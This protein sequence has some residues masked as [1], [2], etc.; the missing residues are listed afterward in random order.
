MYTLRPSLSSSLSPAS[1]SSSL[2]YAPIF[3]HVK[4]HHLDGAALLKGAR[5]DESFRRI[6]VVVVGAE[7]SKYLNVKRVERDKALLGLFFG[8]D[9]LLILTNSKRRFDNDNSPIL[10][11][12]PPPNRRLSPT[13]R[14]PRPPRNSLDAR[15]PRRK[16]PLMSRFENWER[17]RRIPQDFD[18]IH[19][20]ADQ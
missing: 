13:A 11:L 15:L 18:G 20:R 4:E 5:I 6:G 10:P 8:P 17:R 3:N 14:T 1:S 16:V 12:P 7:R 9:S 19:G 2:L